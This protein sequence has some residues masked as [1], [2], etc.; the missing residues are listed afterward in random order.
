[1]SILNRTLFI[2]NHFA[3]FNHDMLSALMLSS[4]SGKKDIVSLLLDLGA[5]PN[6]QDQVNHTATN[7]ESTGWIL[8]I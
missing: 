4:F 5:D 7:F 6:I 3:C 2:V 8:S 1:M